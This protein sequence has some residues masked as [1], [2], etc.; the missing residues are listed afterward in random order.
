MSAAVPEPVAKKK[1]KRCQT[2]TSRKVVKS[3]DARMKLR[4]QREVTKPEK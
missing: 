3:E 1:E 2:A 4:V